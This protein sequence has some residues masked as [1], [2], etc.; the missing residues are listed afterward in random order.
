MQGAP[1]HPTHRTASRPAPFPSVTR[2]LRTP[3]PSLPSGPARLT[4]RNGRRSQLWRRTASTATGTRSR[5]SDWHPASS[6]VGST[7]RS[8]PEARNRGWTRRAD[9][10]PRG[11]S[12]TWGEQEGTGRLKTGLGSDRTE[13]IEMKEGGATT[14]APFRCPRVPIGRPVQREI[15]LRNRR[16]AQTGWSKLD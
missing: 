12:S 4:C 10:P 5:K 14:S 16:K 1:R 13:R 15:P 9:R 2:A 3:G 7:W 8:A 6:R 11:S